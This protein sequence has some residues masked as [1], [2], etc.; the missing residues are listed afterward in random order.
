MTTLP[1]GIP[2][3]RADLAQALGW[4]PGHHPT[5]NGVGEWLTAQDETLTGADLAT[6][7][8]SCPIRVPTS[9]GHQPLTSIEID[10]AFLSGYIH[11][12]YRDLIDAGHGRLLAGSPRWDPL[13]ATNRL[14]A[15]AA[16]EPGGGA[17]LAN[18]TTTATPTPTGWT[19]RG[20]KSWIS[21]MLEAE[22]VVIF[23]RTRDGDIAAY[24]VGLPNTAITIHQLTP[25]GLAGWSWSLIDLNDVPVDSHDR[26]NTSFSVHFARYRAIVAAVVAGATARCYDLLITTWTPDKATLMAER[27]GSYQAIIR[28]CTAFVRSL[29][30]TPPDPHNGKLIKGFVVDQCLT[31][32]RD[33]LAISGAVSFQA[34]HPIRARLHDLEGFQY[35][36][37]P[38]DALYRSAGATTDRSSQ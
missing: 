37:G 8:A 29:A 22:A 21:R 6:V 3:T 12:N 16:T 23:A 19:L 15:I 25:S 36:D 20:T 27:L 11:P 2:A 17:N 10:T 13:Y 30:G 26:L 33:A 1:I 14:I 32:V 31:V 18:L 4:L 38:T 34:G 5:L 35:A 28:A 9:S 7:R 24:A